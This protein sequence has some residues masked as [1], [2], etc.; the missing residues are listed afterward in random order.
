MEEEVQKI[1]NLLKVNEYLN[2]F[3]N[4]IPLYIWKFKDLHMIKK[5]FGGELYIMKIEYS[6]QDEMSRY[7]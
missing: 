4:L 3:P 2:G 1:R 7:Q 6:F 5:G